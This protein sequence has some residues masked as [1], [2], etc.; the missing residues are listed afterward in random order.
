MMIL[1]AVHS[2][3][4]ISSMEWIIISTVDGFIH[5]CNYELV[6]IKVFKAGPSCV[7]S[8]AV[9]PTSPYVLSSSSGDPIKLWDWDK[10]WKCIQTFEK[11]HTTK[12][13]QIVFNPKDTNYFATASEDHTVKV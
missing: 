13:C 9:H 8:L 10:D 6:K 3:K 11:E 12:V 1:I 5:V 2:P 4:F 7:T